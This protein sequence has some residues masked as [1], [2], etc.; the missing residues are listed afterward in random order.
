MGPDHHTDDDDKL[1]R[2]TPLG[3]MHDLVAHVCVQS[4]DATAAPIV[5]PIDDVAAT[6][7]PEER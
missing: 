3:N 2:V 7:P 6:R 4:V 1:P 5:I